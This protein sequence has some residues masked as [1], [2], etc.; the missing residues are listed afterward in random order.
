MKANIETVTTPGS[1]IGNII[2]Q[3]IFQYPAPSTSAASSKSIGIVSIYVLS[4][5]VLNGTPP[6][7]YI[8]AKTARLFMS[9]SFTRRA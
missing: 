7:A 3:T 8:R 9:L 6:A 5:H 1:A 4:S 2:F